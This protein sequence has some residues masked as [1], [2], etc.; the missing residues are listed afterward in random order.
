MRRLISGLELEPGMHILDAGCG[1]GEA[2]TW[3]R[4]EVGKGQ[5]VGIDLAAAHTRAARALAPSDV[6]VAQADLRTLPFRA[7]SF[8]LIWSVNTVNHLQ[9]PQE[10]VQRLAGLL[11]S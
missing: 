3:L 1:T 10:T 4:A 11:R 5:I 9:H 6:L 2:L 7:D 8:D